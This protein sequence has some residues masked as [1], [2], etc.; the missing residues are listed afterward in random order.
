MRNFE[1]GLFKSL[2]KLTLFFLL[3]PVTFNRQSFQKQKVSGTSTQSLSRSRNKFR[4]I[5][6]FV[7]KIWWCNVKQ[8]LSYSKNYI[9]KFMDVNSWHH[10]IFNFHWSFWI[11]K[12]WKGNKLQKFGYLENEKSFLDETT[13]LI[14]F[15]GLSV[16]EKTKFDKK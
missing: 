16:C 6:L 5:T 7:D 11:W 1:K 8:F 13:F 3:N 9:C 14:V 2:K 12:V 10:K 15:K 4:K